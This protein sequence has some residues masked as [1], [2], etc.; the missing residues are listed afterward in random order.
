MKDIEQ[1]VTAILKDARFHNAVAQIINV[2]LEKI[3]EADTPTVEK[4]ES[5]VV[6]N[7]PVKELS[8]PAPKV[9]KRCASKKSFDGMTARA[10]R[11]A[12]RYRIKHNLPIEP[13]LDAALI[14]NCPQ[15][16]PQTKA[17]YHGCTTAA[18]KKR[19][20]MLPDQ[21]TD[22]SLKNAYRREKRAGHVSDE[23]MAEM[24]K[25]FPNYGKR[26]PDAGKK[27]L[28]ISQLTPKGLDYRYRNEMKKF[29]KISDELNDAM[30]VVFPTTYDPV[31]RKFKAPVQKQPK[32]VAELTD[33]SLMIKYYRMRKA[34]N[35]TDE[36]NA[37]MARRFPNEYDS[38][39]RVY[40]KRLNKTKQE[41]VAPAEK[42]PVKP[43]PKPA[44]TPKATPAVTKPVQ[45]PVVKSV[46]T[47]ESNEPSTD[48][49]M[50][51]M[52]GL[53]IVAPVQKPKPRP[54]PQPITD[55]ILNVTVEHGKKGNDIFVN[56]ACVLRNHNGTR[57]QTFLNGEYL[58]VYGTPTD[59][60]NLPRVPQ[61]QIYNTNMTPQTFAVDYFTGK[62]SYAKTAREKDDAKLILQ[63][64]KNTLYVLTPKNTGR[65]FVIPDEYKTR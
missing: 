25:R 8:A 42:A 44:P 19:A 54:K 59:R 29:G 21:M 58:G 64:D 43:A 33:N 10:L 57:L 22:R 36:M 37:E 24:K 4:T 35:V 63:T 61:W 11:L 30:A 18:A 14:K 3:K 23:V 51:A 50:K 38:V 47:D 17:F 20:K 41:K 45:K 55:P 7:V 27:P 1:I 49:M 34:G 2:F 60:S 48:D 26:S 9:K 16:D 15:Y 65:K 12:Y 32:P 31:A 39:N 13:E 62:S 53:D 52:R 56:G 6:I 5:A 28:P 40:S 46:A